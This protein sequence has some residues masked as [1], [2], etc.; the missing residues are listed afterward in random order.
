MTK[1]VFLYSGFKRTW[2]RCKHN[3]DIMLIG[4]RIEY[5]RNEDTHNLNFWQYGIP[6]YENNKAP[7]T[8]VRNVLNQ[9]HNNFMCFAKCSQLDGDV[10]VR[11]RYDIQLTDIIDF[12]KYELHDNVVYIP[13]GHDYR[14]GVNDQFAFGNYNA[15]FKYYSVYLNHQ[16]LFAQGHSFHPESYVLKNLL[17]NGMEVVR[18]TAQTMLIR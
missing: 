12:S 11:N 1:A 16:K 15:M 14:E 17:M 8:V 6:E 7:E 4:D 13:S 2:D 18:L 9:W 5:H 10:F 3:H